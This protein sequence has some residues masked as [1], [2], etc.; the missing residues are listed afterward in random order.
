MTEL[1]EGLRQAIFEK[2][3]EQGDGESRELFKDIVRRVYY[4][5]NLGAQGPDGNNFLH[6]CSMNGS[7]PA[8]LNLLTNSDWITGDY[9]GAGTP[10]PVAD[11]NGL[12]KKLRL[13]MH[14]AAL[15]GN[16]EQVQYYADHPARTFAID[17][18]DILG[19]TP[20]QLARGAGFNALSD[21]IGEMASQERRY[22]IA[23]EELLKR[24]EGKEHVRRPF[25]KFH[26]PDAV[27]SAITYITGISCVRRDAGPVVSVKP[28]EHQKSSPPRIKL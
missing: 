21:K 15:K 9:N 27:K 26:V 25:L 3:Y 24:A 16:E 11:V 1:D 28:T 8:V 18:P 5:G 6:W 12:N 4:M 19:Q 2:K 7:S 17:A 23:I 10:L 14:E 22:N 20:A 13:P